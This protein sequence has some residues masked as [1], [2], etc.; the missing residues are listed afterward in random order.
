MLLLQPG[1]RQD[2]YNP[3]VYPPSGTARSCRPV[4]QGWGSA[5]WRCP[6][7]CPRQHR[8]YACLVKVEVICS[9]VVVMGEGSAAPCARGPPRQ[10]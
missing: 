10:V 7:P 8:F 1:I 9:L 4:P 6:G 5:S 2:F 3:A